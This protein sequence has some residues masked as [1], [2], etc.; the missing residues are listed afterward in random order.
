MTAD[1]DKYQSRMDELDH[2]A[3]NFVYPEELNESKKIMQAMREDVASLR[4][5][6]EFEVMRIEITEHFLLQRWA[7]VVP[8]DMEDEMKPLFKKLKE[9]K[10]EKKCDASMGIQDIVKKWNLFCP[11]VCELR[12][13]RR[14]CARGSGRSS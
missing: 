1:L 7:Q 5:L 12:D 14:P 10:V 6:W 8:S 3:K 13:P 9:V 11:L 4:S 2:I